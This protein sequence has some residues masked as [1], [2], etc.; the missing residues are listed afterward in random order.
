MKVRQVAGVVLY[1]KDLNLVF[2]VRGNANK[3]GEL[4]S[5]FG[6]SVK[7]GETP[8][9]AVLREL[10]EEITYKPKKLKYM[11]K[12][13]YVIEE[14]YPWKGT[15]IIQHVYISPATNE[16]L[17]SEVH[18]GDGMIV[19]SLEEAIKGDG[20]PKKSTRFLKKIKKELTSIVKKQKNR[21]S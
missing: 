18:E 20:F 11:G 6:G 21:N 9:Q 3:V 12:F 8:K 19:I 2:Q 17:Q 7:P 4:Y 1:D 15:K 10:S 13:E 5:F 14:E 16:L